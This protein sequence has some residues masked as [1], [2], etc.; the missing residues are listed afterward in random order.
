M[1][2][3]EKLG[4]FYLGRRWDLDAKTTVA[5]EPIL[6]DSRDLTTHA[7]CVGMT[8]SGKTG[9]CLALLEEAAID[10]IPA[11]AIDP[12]GDLGNLLL[13]FPDLRPADFRPWIDEGEAARAGLDVDAQAERVAERWRKG[14]A[15]WDQAPERIARFRDAVDLAIY[16][17]G[18]AAGLPLSVLRSLSAPVPDADP[19][20][21]RDRTVGT[22]SALLGLLGV[23]ADPLRSR[24]HVL[25][26]KILE[27]AW[28]EGRDVELATLV[29]DIASPPID[30][31]GAL[32]LESFFPAKE[33]AALSLALNSLLA[34]PGFA[35]WLEGEPL[36]VDRLLWTAD[37]KPRLSILSIA[38]LSEAERMFFVSLLLS[39]V[40]TWVR[41][42]SGTSSLRAILYMDEVAGFFP[43]VAAP[44]SKAPML[45]LLKQARAYGLGVVLATQN[46]VDLDY[47]G[48]S[49]AG[50]W[51]LGRLQTERDKARVL[52][53][54]EG[55]SSAAGR[56][57]DRARTDRIL[58][59][60]GQ[61]VFLMNDV[62][63]D[64]PEVF[65]S[66]WALS[67]LRGPLTRVQIQSLMAD[68]R[69]AEA[70]SS[71][72]DPAS[73]SEGRATARRADAGLDRPLV[74]HDVKEIFAAATAPRPEGARL[75]Y[76]PALLAGA[77]LRFVDAKAGV[78]EWREAVTVAPFGPGDGEP[79]WGEATHAPARPP[80]ESAP[81]PDAG[82]APLPTAAARA[83]SYPAWQKS[84]ADLLYRTQGLEVGHCPSLGQHGRPGEDLRDFRIRMAQAGH[85]RR[86]AEADRIRERFASRVQ[87]AQEAVD[88][89]AARAQQRGEEL[90]QRKRDS[91]LTIGASVIGALF[92]GKKL[93]ATNI[94]RATTAARSIGRTSQK[95]SQVEEA[96]A[97][98]ARHEERLE[99]V[100][101]ELAEA[102]DRIDAEWDSPRVES[103]RI[104]PRKTDLSVEAPVLAWLPSWV[105]DDG[106]ETAAWG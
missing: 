29:R 34:S 96:E 15:E 53:G 90:S 43:P 10:G 19:E 31:V 48:L 64:A 72:G 79:Q 35:S 105:G 83:K 68:R 70:A 18:S 47:K 17:P 75:V 77:R 81:R 52:D 13:S 104:A 9:L 93:S 40:L 46:P 100:E 28:S 98:R 3:Y 94:G 45:S 97:Q 22:V 65:Q 55:A 33:R 2:D 99:D 8:G 86:D 60:L 11:I 4:V 24:E 82:F 42:Q 6:Y 89:A 56:E 20:D 1:Q 69:K 41:R 103:V 78:D 76:R 50:T 27:K 32:D 49:N 88:R 84:L 61:R 44:P 66:R 101:R 57:L 37:G 21:V 74:P 51:F 5:D 59:A 39:E 38:H 54:L 25:L 71:T 23:D 7:V 80:L 102:L 92:S 14:L 91:M 26:S 63:R 106:R 87:R 67:Y 58:S 95:Q 62:H 36:D 85:E 73:G 30:R 12:K 16:T